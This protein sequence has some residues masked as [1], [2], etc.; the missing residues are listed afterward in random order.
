MYTLGKR[1]DRLAGAKNAG[2]EW[3][4]GSPGGNIVAVQCEDKKSEWC[5]LPGKVAVI[6]IYQYRNIVRRG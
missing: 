5:S 2:E 3:L 6:A 1:F 4:N